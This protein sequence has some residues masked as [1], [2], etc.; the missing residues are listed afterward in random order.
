MKN[1]RFIVL[2]LR[3]LVLSPN[4]DGRQVTGLLSGLPVKNER[5]FISIWNKEDQKHH[6][7]GI[8]G[9]MISKMH[10]LL[11]EGEDA[12]E[13]IVFFSPRQD[14]QGKIDV[15]ESKQ[16][17][18]KAVNLVGVL[19]KKLIV[20]ANV[21]PDGEQL[22]QKPEKV[23]LGYPDHPFA[24]TLASAAKKTEEEIRKRVE[25]TPLKKINKTT[26]SGAAGTPA[27]RHTS[28]GPA[29][30]TPAARNTYARNNNYTYHREPTLLTRRPNQHVKKRI[31]EIRKLLQGLAE[32]EPEAAAP[33]PAKVDKNNSSGAIARRMGGAAGSLCATCAN[34]YECVRQVEY[35]ECPAY[36]DDRERRMHMSSWPDGL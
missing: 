6:I 15:L 8:Q 21:E 9:T 10:W 13:G 5:E 22:I 16:I 30:R 32:K 1:S 29:N 18:R 27:A 28:F 20:S 31:A 4:E 2:T 11:G 19:F 35:H 23:H 14:G 12:E 24:E 3:P 25:Q 26:L 34:F 36:V 7:T 17:M 33:V